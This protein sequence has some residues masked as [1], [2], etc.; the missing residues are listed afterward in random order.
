[1][2]DIKLRVDWRNVGKIRKALE[3]STRSYQQVL[4]NMGAR[5]CSAGVVACM[6]KFVPQWKVQGLR[7]IGPPAVVLRLMRLVE[8]SSLTELNLEFLDRNDTR[9]TLQPCTITLN[10][11]K[12]FH[13]I[14]NH[15]TSMRKIKIFRLF[16][17]NLE[18]AT[19]VLKDDED[20]VGYE[21]YP[22]VDLLES[23]KLKYLEMDVMGE[24]VWEQFFSLERP[25]LERLVIR[26][27]YSVRQF[28]DWD[29]KTVFTN[30]PN[31]RWL[32][33]ARQYYEIPYITQLFGTTQLFE[34]DIGSLNAHKLER[35]NL[36]SIRIS[37]RETL[38][39]DKLTELTCSDIM[40]S[41]DTFTLFAPDLTRLVLR[42]CQYHR[43]K[44]RVGSQLQTLAIDCF[45]NDCLK[46][47]GFF[48]S[49]ENLHELYL[50]VDRRTLNIIDK[51]GTL[52]SLEALE[53]TFHSKTNDHDCSGLVRN[54]LDNCPVIEELTIK[55]ENCKGKLFVHPPLFKQL[56][57][58]EL[59]SLDVEELT[60][61]IPSDV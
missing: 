21:H 20:C 59:L 33:I 15:G 34:F 5:E 8:F 12:R 22:L 4:V 50:N 7:V 2:E 36:K 40:V 28:R 9:G 46:I 49:L 16:V 54:I 60:I 47:D 27:K 13:C 1:M 58:L 14:Q 38:R 35:L 29:W 19:I 57:D 26:P 6:A 42:K 11:L 43:F 41:G 10:S 30:M 52:P 3:K 25:L 44:L 37:G 53:V 17:P 51:L 48:Q 45:R 61:Q 55:N 32:K 23:S 31:L 18:H 39:C 24:S 56:L